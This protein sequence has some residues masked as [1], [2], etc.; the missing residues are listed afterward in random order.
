MTYPLLRLFDRLPAVG[1]AQKLLNARA[2][3]SLVADGDFGN[4]TRAAVMSFQRSHPGLSI[5]GDI[6]TQTWPRL[7]ASTPDVLRIVDC[8]DVFDPS[9]YRLEAGDIRRA[10]G[11]PLLIGG[12]CNGVEQAV[13]NIVNSVQAGTVFLLRFHGHGAPGVAGVSDGQGD[14]GEDRSSIDM[15][16]WP[17]LRPIMARLAPIFGPYGCI[18][19]MHCETG[20]GRSGRTMLQNVATTVGVPATGGIQTQYGGGLRTF[21]FEGPTYTAFPNGGNLRNWSSRLPEFV[22][23]SVA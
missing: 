12:M 2:G 22:G 7:K 3:S 19:F 8:I 14:L 16:N 1:V 4:R 10:G 9:L 15:A 11:D 23:M 6:G 17:Y 13:T 18:Q 5:D 20:S 21:R